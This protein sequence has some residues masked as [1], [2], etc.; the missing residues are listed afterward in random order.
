ML[1]SWLFT[2]LKSIDS[3]AFS[4]D[5]LVDIIDY[6]PKNPDISI[7]LIDNINLKSH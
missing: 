5:I 2:S 6:L 7:R 3:K 1:N 4:W